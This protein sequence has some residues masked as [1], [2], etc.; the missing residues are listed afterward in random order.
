MDYGFDHFE[1]VRIARG[2][3][4]LTTA[5]VMEGDASAV[6]IGAVED[7][8]CVRTEGETA[9][10]SIVYDI[11][12]AVKAPVKDGNSPEKWTFTRKENMSILKICI[13]SKMSAGRNSARFFVYSEPKRYTFF[14]G[15]E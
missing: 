8:T 15:D 7:I 12:D 3:V 2:E 1:T 6:K 4:P 13:I 11:P 14:P 5:A 10:L 9:G